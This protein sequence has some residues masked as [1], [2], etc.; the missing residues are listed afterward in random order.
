MLDSCVKHSPRL[1]YQEQSPAQRRKPATVVKAFA[2]VACACV[3]FSVG[4]ALSS[5]PLVR[6]SLGEASAAVARLWQVPIDVSAPLHIPQT[7]SLLNKHAQSMAMAFRVSPALVGVT[8]LA[9]L[10]SMV[11]PLARFLRGE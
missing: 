4:L 7:R 9:S 10:V 2:V 1:R 6:T 3:G 5:S 8:L 11:D